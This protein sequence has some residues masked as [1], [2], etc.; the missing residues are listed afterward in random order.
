MLKPPDAPAD[1]CPHDGKTCLGW[2]ETSLA[3]EDDGWRATG[4]RTHAVVIG[5]GDYSESRPLQD[6][7]P[8]SFAPL[9]GAARAAYRFAEY[10]R[11]E[12]HEPT[13]RSLATLRLLLSP[14]QDECA[15]LRSMKHRPATTNEVALAVQDW[16]YNCNTHDQNLAILYI[17]GHGVALRKAVSTV[18]LA[19]ALQK[20][21]EYIG[22]INLSLIQDYMGGCA[23]KDNIFV[24]DCCALSS[25]DVPTVTGAGGVFIRPFPKG[26]KEREN[27]VAINAARVG[28]QTF[29]L[30]RDGTLLSRG[31]LGAYTDRM[32]EDALLRTAG[33]IILADGINGRFGITYDRLKVEINPKLRGLLRSINHPDDKYEATI[34]GGYQNIAIPE[35]T[36][37]FEVVLRNVLT[38]RTPPVRIGFQ[39]GAGEGKPLLVDNAFDGQEVRLPAGR[40][41]PYVEGTDGRR[42][43]FESALDLVKRQELEVP[44]P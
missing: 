33:S 13:G 6:S 40:Y 35:P 18:F 42:Y 4:G 39:R 38:G 16:A 31:L 32:G 30:G 44:P 7:K 25:D 34:G 22:A 24:Y 8:A 9:P 10:L 5:V 3:Y 28:R 17:V 29:A 41:S 1:K 43:Y 19:D 26:G 2:G 37:R 23:A 36:P 21:N 14:V 11:K 20:A 15:D 12:F 27:W